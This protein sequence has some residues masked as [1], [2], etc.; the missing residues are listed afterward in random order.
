[1]L[2][3]EI[4]NYTPRHFSP[5]RAVSYSRVS[6]Q[7]QAGPDKVSLSEQRRLAE[8]EAQHRGWIIGPDYCDA[9]V[10]GQRHAFDDREALHRMLADAKAG[11]FDVLIIYNSDRIGRREDVF[12]NVVQPLFYDYRVPILDLS[13]P[14]QIDDPREFDPFK[15]DS[16]TLHFG[17]AGMMASLDQR[18]RT[19]RMVAGKRKSA[20]VG[21]YLPSVPP[22]GYKFVWEVEADNPPK[23]QLAI[24]STEYPTLEL[25]IQWGLRERLSFLEI[26][27]KLDGMGSRSR[28]GRAWRKP[29]IGKMLRNPF[30]AGYVTYGNKIKSRHGTMIKNTDAATVIRVAHNYPHPVTDEQFAEMLAI[31]KA[32]KDAPPRCHGAQNPLSGLLKCASCGGTLSLVRNKYGPSRN[33]YMCITRRD[34][35]LACSQ[36]NLTGLYVFSCIWEQIE[37]LATRIDQG[38]LIGDSE[39]NLIRESQVKLTFLQNELGKCQ[40]ELITLTAR[41][42]NL[43]DDLADRVISRETYTETLT[44][45]AAKRVELQSRQQTL[46]SQAD[47]AGEGA[48]TVQRQ[49]DF[50]TGWRELSEYARDVPYYDWNEQ[51]MRDIKDCLKSMFREFRLKS[52]YNEAQNTLNIKIVCEVL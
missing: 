16:V 32:H 2:A 49:I 4:D 41:E 20:E 30:Y 18:Q 3:E 37:T 50:A 10:S 21:N 48:I 44:R 17:F 24:D 28:E 52:E 27:R 51:F 33:V 22:Y 23:K 7:K 29:S 12:H 26:T 5:V 8:Q 25:I 40:K 11:R 31:R 35:N 1:M 9:G 13:K 39:E 15:D 6:S 38:K 45:Y 46:Q 19:R 43:L 36:Q 34:N 14:L 47:A 42:E